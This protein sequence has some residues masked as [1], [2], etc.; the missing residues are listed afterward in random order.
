[1]RRLL[2]MLLLAAFGLPVAAS[3]LVLAQENEAHLP[4]CCRR[5]G[6]HHCAMAVGQASNT[7]ALSALCPHYPQ[8]STSTPS[9]NFAALASPAPLHRLPVVVL[10]AARRAEAQRRVSRERS[11]H[12][13]GPPTELL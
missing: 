1:M 5:H 3:A 13:R 2:A 4:A 6:A 7:P 12:K 9:G 10:S 8:P 11:R